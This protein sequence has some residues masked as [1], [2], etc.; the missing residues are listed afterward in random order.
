MQNLKRDTF[1]SYFNVKLLLRKHIVKHKKV[2]MRLAN[3]IPNKTNITEKI[4]NTHGQGK[5]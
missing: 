3:C 1:D 2:R 4:Q 5:K